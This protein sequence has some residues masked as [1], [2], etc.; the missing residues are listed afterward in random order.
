MVGWNIPGF[1]LEMLAEKE[2]IFQDSG[3]QQRVD[4]FG[5]CSMMPNVTFPL[6]S[7]TLWVLF[8]LVAPLNNRVRNLNSTQPWLPSFFHK[9]WQMYRHPHSR[10]EH[11]LRPSS[12]LCC[13]QLST[14]GSRGKTGSQTT[15]DVSNSPT[16]RL[17]LCCCGL[18]LPSN[19]STSLLSVSLLK[20]SNRLSISLC[21]NQNTHTHTNRLTCILKCRKQ[22]LR[23]NKLL[24]W[25]LKK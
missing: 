5:L 20:W 17:S 1:F 4:L 16:D 14:W 6:L 21:G 3:V 22:I 10:L 15:A 13:V 18:P 24:H 23:A 11:P 25:I 2:L 7:A 9:R 12:Y 8:R 19:P